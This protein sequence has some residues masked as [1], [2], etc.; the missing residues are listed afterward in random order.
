MDMVREPA[1]IDV[2][3]LNITQKTVYPKRPNIIEGI[4]DKISVVNR[5]SFTNLP[6]LAY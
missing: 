2:P 3:K 4:P 5:I 6:C 1:I